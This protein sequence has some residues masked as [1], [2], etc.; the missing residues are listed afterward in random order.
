MPRL[1]RLRSAWGLPN[2][3]S[4]D[5]RRLFAALRTRGWDGVEASLDDIGTSSADRADAVAAAQSEGVALVLSAYSSWANYD[6]PYEHL[7]VQQHADAMK[8]QLTQIADLHVGSGG[9]GGA[10]PIVHVNAHSGTDAWAEAEAV[11]YFEAALNAGASLGTAVP[12]ISHE[13]HRGR[14]LGCPFRTAR[15]LE[16]VPALRLTSDFSHW[17]VA[18]ERLLDTPAESEWLATCIAPAVD[19]IH[20]RVGAPQAPQVPGVQAAGWQ[21]AV[22]RHHAWWSTV[23]SA[24]EAASIS[25]RAATHSATLEYGPLEVSEDDGE[26]VGYTPATLGLTEAVAGVA[27]E[28]TLEEARDMLTAR[29]EVWHGEEANLRRG[30]W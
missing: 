3:V 8:S 26:Y 21:R 9:Y 23:W 20:A 25:S 16:R 2:L 6:G 29:F 15:L 19:H 22:A 10:S 12:D 4:G 7:S 13:T 11:D 14:Y 5:R 30:A 28:Q 1:L 27:L 24:R 18:C 17:V